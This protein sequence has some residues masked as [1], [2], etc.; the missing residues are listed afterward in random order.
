MKKL[1]Y[2]KEKWQNMMEWG[3]ILV[4]FSFLVLILAGIVAASPEP[5]AE[6]SF[7]KILLFVVLVILTIAEVIFAIWFIIH[8]TLGR[9]FY[10]RYMKEMAD[11]DDDDPV[12]EAVVSREELKIVYEDRHHIETEVFKFS[13]Y[14][15]TVKVRENYQIPVF[16]VYDNMI[17]KV[18]LPYS[19]EE[20]PR[21]QFYKVL[22]M[23]RRS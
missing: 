5:L 2:S 13:D 12:R 8:L 11:Y 6:R 22:K 14:D 18:V 9:R 19:E 1:G 17:T 21:W 3:M 7:G 15:V 23:K 10:R 16:Y 20:N 4:P